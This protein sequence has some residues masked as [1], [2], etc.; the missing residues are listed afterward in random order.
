VRG[1]REDGELALDNG[2][3]HFILEDGCDGVPKAPI[4]SGHEGE[5][6]FY[7]EALGLPKEMV[8]DIEIAS[9][10]FAYPT[11]SKSNAEVGVTT[12]GELVFVSGR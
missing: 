10:T 8:V 7:I 12:S 6:V 5:K 3:L 1:P 2:L 9:K 4:E 11:R